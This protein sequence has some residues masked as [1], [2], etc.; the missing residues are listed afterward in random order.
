MITDES[1]GYLILNAQRRDEDHGH[2]AGV[3]GVYNRARYEAEIRV[4][5]QVILDR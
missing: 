4:T 3:A 2:H 5:V 1:P